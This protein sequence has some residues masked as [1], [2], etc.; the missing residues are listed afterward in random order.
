MALLADDVARLWTTRGLDRVVLGG[1][2]LGSYVALAFMARHPDR[3]G[4]LV[5][6]DTKAPADGDQ[7]REDRLKMADRVLA[8]GTEFVPEV[9]L[10]KLLGET[11]RE[12]RPEVVEKVAALIREQA[13]EA[14]ASAGAAWRPAAPPTCAPISVPT[15][16]VTGE[17]DAVTGPEIGREYGRRHPRCPLPVG[18]GGRAPG[19]SGAAG[20]R[21]RSAPRPPRPALG[22]RL[23]CA[24]TTRPTHLVRSD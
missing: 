2:S 5:L 19:Q 24:M 1:L 16:V 13:P 12:H 15:L 3:V 9:M 20:D 8:E 10:P 14:I 23:L 22:L 21:E 6:L 18:R 4:G 17:E 11:T 7:A